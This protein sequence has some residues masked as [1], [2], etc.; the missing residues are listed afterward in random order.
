MV[1]LSLLAY[2]RLARQLFIE[3]GLC[4]FFFRLS[5]RLLGSEAC[6]LRPPSCFVVRFGFAPLLLLL[7]LECLGGFALGLETGSLLFLTG[8]ALGRFAGL[9]LG[10]S[11]GI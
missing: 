10:P 9:F 11:R 1:R 6:L 8:F 4:L 2:F 3:P 7:S 5:G